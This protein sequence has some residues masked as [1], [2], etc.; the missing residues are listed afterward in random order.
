MVFAP[1][2]TDVLLCEAVAGLAT[3]DQ[4]VLVTRLSPEQGALLT[5]KFPEG[6]YWPE[7]HLFACNATPLRR[8]W[9]EQPQ[10]DGPAACL[11]LTA[12]GADMPVAL[13]ALGTAR[14]LGLAPALISDVGVAGLHRIEPH[15]PALRSAKVCIVCAGMEGALPSVLGGLVRAPIIAVPTSVGYGASF[16]GMAAL[17]AMLNSCSP[18]VGVVNIDN[19]FGAAVLALK[20]LDNNHSR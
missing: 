10:S 17:L 1:G 4:P 11:V 14:F 2:K 9:P 15:L 3:D 12:G 13:E 6:E 16:G 5:T 8:G 19:G 7:A 20:I 18:G